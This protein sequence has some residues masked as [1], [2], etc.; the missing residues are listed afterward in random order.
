[1]KTAGRIKKIIGSAVFT[2]ILVMIIVAVAIY[3]YLLRSRDYISEAKAYV[4]GTIETG[5]NAVAP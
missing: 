5:S 3:V 2:V 1:M 4:D